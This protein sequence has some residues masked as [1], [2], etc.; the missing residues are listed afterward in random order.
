MLY[1]FAGQRGREYLNDFLT[2]NVDTGIVE[3]VSD[4]TRREGCQ[5]GE[6]LYTARVGRAAR[7]VS[8]CTLHEEGGL[9]GW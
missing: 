2:Y 5:G 8:V 1:I 4:G 3:Q 7:V 6:C 9:A